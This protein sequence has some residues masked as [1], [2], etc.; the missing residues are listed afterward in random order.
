MDSSNSILAPF[1]IPILDS[2][3]PK[4]HVHNLKQKDYT[5]QYDVAGLL[6]Q[7]VQGFDRACNGLSR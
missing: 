3:F 4:E 7:Y 1:K 5:A 6:I 2:F